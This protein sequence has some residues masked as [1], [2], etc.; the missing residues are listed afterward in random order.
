M[1]HI[2][3]LKL[4]LGSFSLDDVSLHIKRGEYFVLLGPSGAGK[5][6]LVET[7][8]GLI[9]PNSGRIIIDG[10]E[11]TAAPP[12][13]RRIGYVPQDYA[14]F[15]TRTVEGN[16]LFGRRAVFSRRQRESTIAAAKLKAAKKNGTG[17]EPAAAD[18]Q[19]VAGVESNV[20]IDHLIDSLGIRPLLER[21]ID[22]LS[23]GERQR[24]ALARA[25]AAE[26]KILILDEPVSALDEKTRDETCQ[27]LRRLHREAGMTTIHICHNL[28]EMLT[29]ADRVGVIIAGRIAQ[30]DSPRG[31][32][33]RPAT[34][35]AARLLQSENVLPVSRIEDVPGPVEANKDTLRLRIG[36]TTE[37]R[38][39]R[40]TVEQS[41]RGRQWYAV[42]RPEN[43]RVVTPP[44]DGYKLSGTEIAGDNF[45]SPDGSVALS[46][47][48]VNIRDAGSVI[49]LTVRIE[50]EI[51]III[52]IDLAT[53][54]RHPINPGSIIRLQIDPQNVHLVK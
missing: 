25:L 52:T 28:A 26:P 14:L 35:A 12:A 38:A 44:V 42:I 6:M 20:Q 54:A 34:L 22:G 36:R 21:R 48:L 37:L 18:L 9:R 10:E 13:H 51:E 3:S 15:P 29:V 24:V 2:E 5:T 40:H 30:V 4:Q 53:F 49:S 47:R 17:A 33:D 7:L 50:D 43:I 46:G 27:L 19:Q 45:D 11:M 1:I 31:V 16:I 39:A 41:Y 23:G 8:C 32:L